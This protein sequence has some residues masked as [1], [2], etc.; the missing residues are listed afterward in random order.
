MENSIEFRLWGPRALFTDPVTKVGGEKYTYPVPTY[1]ALKG[2]TESIY[3]KPTIVWHV[4]KV[5]VMRP[6]RNESVNAKLVRYND[7]SRSDLS[8]FTYLRDVE[9]QVKVHFEW[10]DNRPDLSGDR[11]ENKHYFQAQRALD[12][13]GRRDIFLGTRECQGY[14]EPC[15]FG[16]GEGIYDN[17]PSYPFGFMF[18]GFDYADETGRGE[19]AAR[20][21]NPEMRNGVIEF[22]RPEE[23]PTVKHVRDYKPKTIGISREEPE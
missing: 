4:D 21:W 22:I 23:C 1:Q 19:L 8:I 5:R 14:V 10:N 2:I 15:R 20:F 17:T 18:H 12:K 11:N 7:A 16:E 6:I 3:W 13:G 9:Y